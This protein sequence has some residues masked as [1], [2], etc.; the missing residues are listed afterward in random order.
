MYFYTIKSYPYSL[1]KVNKYLTWELD[2]WLALTLDSMLNQ[3]ASLTASSLKI[4]YSLEQV[5][6]GRWF[7]QYV[8]KKKGVAFPGRVSTLV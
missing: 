7:T 8:L 3:K 2:P 4:Y 5:F 6:I 1:F